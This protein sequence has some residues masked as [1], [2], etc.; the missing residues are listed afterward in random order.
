VHLLRLPLLGQIFLI[1]PFRADAPRSAGGS[2]VPIVGQQGGV[3]NPAI[4]IGIFLVFV[5]VTLV[6][7]LRAS[8]SPGTASDC[9]AA[10]S[11]VTGPQNGMAIAGDHLSAAAFLGIAGLVAVYGLDGLLFALV[12]LVAGLVALLLV[13]E[14]LRNTGRFALGDVLSFR[15]RQRPVRAA[16]A[17]ST[18]AVSFLFLAAQLAGAG[19]LVALL[20]NLTSDLGQRLVI[21]TVGAVMTLYVLVGGMRGTTWV[22]VV[23]TGMLLATG[24][25]MTAWVLGAYGLNLSTLLGA[26][27]LQHPAGT[28]I[29]EPGLQYGESTMSRLDFVSLAIGGVLGPAGLPHIL[30]RLHTAPTGREARRSVVWAIWLIGLSLLCV[31]VLGYA[32]TALVGPERIVAAPGTANSAIPLLAFELGGPVVLA[33][34]AAVAFVTI[35]AVVAGV[36]AAA[37]ASFAHDVHAS[38]I[39]RG[40]PAVNEA[41]VTRITVVVIGMLGVLGGIGAKDQNVAFLVALAFA[42]A[43]SANLPTLLYSLY[44]RRFTTTGALCSIYGGLASSGLLIAFSPVVS[45]TDSAIFPG[46]DFAL[47]P[48]TNPGIVSVPL[49]F[50]LGFLGSVLGRERSNRRRFAE[51]EVRTLTGTIVASPARRAIERRRKEEGAVHGS[52]PLTPLGPRSPFT[53]HLS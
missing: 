24:V 21:T 53:S 13:A 14:P 26:A 11:T 49:S 51:M 48:L 36:T 43:A 23:K 5:S 17:T 46:A 33:I 34:V 16:A 6:I 8:R 28:G 32:A 12:A 37:A 40:D 2:P 25:A 1:A 38:V 22:Q 3:G 50:L 15:M 30:T 18:L 31:V 42:V 10:G 27:V 52:R 19:A 20:L 47:F 41:R 29:L 45:G 7:A 9:Y 4:N 44:W 39:K 35:L